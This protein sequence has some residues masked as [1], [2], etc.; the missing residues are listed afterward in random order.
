MAEIITRYEQLKSQPSAIS[1]LD[2]N[3][4]DY[5]N[6]NPDGD[7]RDV[8]MQDNSWPVFFQLSEL[9]L[10]LYSWYDFGEDATLLEIGAGFGALTG[11]FCQKCKRVIATENSK[12]RAEALYKRYKNV[13]NLEIYV[14]DI[15]TMEFDHPFDFIILTGLLE[16]LGKGTK[17]R[18]VYVN[19]LRQLTKL[20]SPN[21][22]LLLAV[23]NRF[24]LKYV[25]GAEEPHTGRPFDG[26]NR[27]PFGTRGCSFSKEEI[28]DIIR[29]AGLDTYKFYYP[30]P[31]YK[32]PQMIYS[33][34]YQPKSRIKERLVP[35]Y[36]KKDSL[37]AVESEL[38]DE[39]VENGV[40]EFFA[41]SFFI[42]CS[43]AATPCAIDFATVTPD[44]GH[45]KGTVTAILNNNTVR[46]HAIFSEGR[47][48]IREQYNNL[49]ELMTRGIPVIDIVLEEDTIIMPYRNEPLASV[50][51]KNAVI[52]KTI[53]LYR[54]FE[55]LYTYILKSSEHVASDLNALLPFIKEMS[56]RV[57]KADKI[58]RTADNVDFG[59]ILS[60]AYIEMIPMNSFWVKDDFLFFDQEFTFDHYPANYVLFRALKNTYIFI[61]EA[62]GM[63]PLKEMKKHFRL[64]Q[65]WD[66]YERRD[67]SFI[68]EVRQME[69]NKTFYEWT[70]INKER[71]YNKAELLNHKAEIIADY[72]V[73]DKMK[74]IWSI[75]LRLLKTIERVCKEHNLQYYIIRGTLLGAVRHKGFIPWDDDIDIALM[76]EDY[77]KL[78]NLPT[79]VFGEEVFLQTAANDMECFFGAYSRLRYNHSTAIDLKNWGRACNQGVWI[80][81]F[82]IDTYDESEEFR[83]KQRNKIKRLYEL[84]YAKT[85]GKGFRRYGRLSRIKWIWYKL[86]AKLMNKQRLIE[87]LDVCC[88]YSKNPSLELLGIHTHYAS[89]KIFYKE[90]FSG[91]V[92]LEFEDLKLPAPA[93][94]Q[95]CLEMTVAKNYMIYPPVEERVPHHKELFIPELPYQTFNQRYVHSFRDT[96]DKDIILFGAG[97]M[98]EDY[99]K[100]FGEKYPPVFLV[101]NNPQK[102][103]TMKC[104]IEVRNPTEILNIPSERR[105]LFL[106]NVY[107]KQIEKQLKNMGI[108]EYCIYVQNREWI[109]K[110]ENQEG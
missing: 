59:I 16:R 55:R 66:L 2:Q 36:V 85:Y 31:D 99:M 110:D 86:I 91:T 56:S 43:V 17:N 106:C 45:E 76:R 81:I 74:K 102:W 19:Y 103:G 28:T 83:N 34:N 1:E 107:Y 71:I 68:M 97:L 20:L 63:I 87:K 95:R 38:Y 24:G 46:K 65:V 101:D 108:T 37:V 21:G 73:S 77:N 35:Y 32:L 69:A 79:D 26:L 96:T 105:K 18:E 98:V 94:Y 60:K 7:F 62:Q 67:Q 12:V 29:Q 88:A 10:G 92:Y 5:I 93:G 44:R 70:R 42:E 64:E 58:N 8:V 104:G 25:C 53:D 49:C 54:Y 11:L 82:P 9:R 84:L 52:E 61:P 47:K 90:D 3:I 23:E 39:V 51:L 4:I 14:G 30:L 41:N 57:D 27:Y 78:L 109:L 100:R 40:F 13:S 50:Y 48:N 75:Q 22:K 15:T 80:D 72:K 6:Q 33:Q 89:S